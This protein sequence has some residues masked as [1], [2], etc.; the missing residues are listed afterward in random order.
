VARKV[1]R[2]IGAY[3]DKFLNS[4]IYTAYQSGKQADELP[5]TLSGRP[6]PVGKPGKFI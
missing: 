6:M 2:L 5:Q 3:A 1:R 4:E